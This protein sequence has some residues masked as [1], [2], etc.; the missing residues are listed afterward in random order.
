MTSI[1]PANEPPGATPPPSMPLGTATQLLRLG[2]TGPRRPVDDLIDRLGEPDGA[3]WLIEALDQGVLAGLGSAVGQLA[4]GEA[5]V[6]QLAEIKER[7]QSQLRTGLDRDSRLAGI[8]GYFLTLAAGLR[9]HGHA[10][11]SRSRDDLDP[12]LLD[13]ATV[14]P[15]PFSELLSDATLVA[16]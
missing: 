13:L 6:E 5:T 4:E 8:A 1:P 2:L 14:A 3:N 12:V 11:S 10:L 16:R 9:H 7:S 15:S